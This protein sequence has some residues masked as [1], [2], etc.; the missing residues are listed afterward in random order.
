MSKPLSQD[1][2]MGEWS[3]LHGNVQ[4]SGI[5]KGWLRI[6]YR[7]A[8]AISK[9]GISANALTCLGVLFAIATA[10]ASPSLWSAFF[11]ALSLALDGIDGSLAVVTGQASKLGAIFDASADRIS[12]ALW[13]V[14]FYRLGVPLSL[15][16]FLWLLAA[17]QEYARARIGSAGV[18]DVGIITPAER[19]VRASFLF[20]AIVAWHLNFSHGWISAIAQIILALQGIS[21]IL[22]LRYAF[23]SLK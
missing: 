15:V 3:S 2:F 9:L 21:L 13:A 20:V 4:A 16:L 8:R 11:L 18:K 10:I 14:A 23:I 1:E 22:V 17:I 7:C 6:S 5:V 12:E 19:P